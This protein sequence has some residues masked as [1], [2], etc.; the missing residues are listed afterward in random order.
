[1][2]PVD[3]S[4]S[5]GPAPPATSSDPDPRPDATSV[6]AADSPGDAAIELHFRRVLVAI[7]G[8]SASRLALAAAV[9]AA[10]RDGALLTVMTGVR[11][12]A[13]DAAR[14]SAAPMVPTDS[15]D[16]ADDDAERVLRAAV[17]SLPKDIGVRTVLRRGK[18]GPC[19]VEEADHGS[20]DAVFLGA[21]GLGRIAA[22]VGSVSQ[23]VVHHAT[24]AVFIAHPARHDT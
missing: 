19:I 2:R 14:W 12:V 4:S 3:V 23:Y 10:R 13:A 15:Q 1:M 5:A 18:A 22:M 20:Y 21:R 17:N 16:A 11:D 8:S 9:T 6:K 7:D 24:T